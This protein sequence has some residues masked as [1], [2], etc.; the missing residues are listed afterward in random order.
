MNPD[1]P[2]K[3]GAGPVIPT[4]ANCAAKI[5]LRPGHCGNLTGQRICRCCSANPAQ[6]HTQTAIVAAIALA[7]EVG[8]LNRIAAIDIATTK[9]GFQMNAS[10]PK[11]WVNRYKGRASA[12]SNEDV[13]S[14]KDQAALRRA[15]L[16]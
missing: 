11:K 2:S 5:A 7:K 13:N 9:R 15:A 4:R 14:Q 6:V 3:M 1:R 10:E 12:H 16:A 8:D